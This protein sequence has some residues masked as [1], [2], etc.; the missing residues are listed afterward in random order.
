MT[1]GTIFVL[2]PTEFAEVCICMYITFVSTQLLRQ[3]QAV[4]LTF[5]CLQSGLNECN[6]LSLQPHLEAAGFHQ[7]LCRIA[8]VPIVLG[9]SFS[10]GQL[11]LHTSSQT[12]LEMKLDVPLVSSF[13]NKVTVSCVSNVSHFFCSLA[14]LSEA[15]SQKSELIP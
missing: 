4:H 8:V 1:F 13:Q 11:Q 2:N 6:G 3:S 7:S 14:F 5:Q 9:R 12:T 10:G 15:R